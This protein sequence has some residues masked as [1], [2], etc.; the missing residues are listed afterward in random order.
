MNEKTNTKKK[1]LTGIVVS[2]KMKDTVVVAVSRYV[3]DPKYKKYVKRVKRYKAH[4]AGNTREEG[5]KVVI[6]PSKPISKD[7]RFVVVNS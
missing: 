5:E 6:A 4:D 2:N 7:K 1:T 3:K